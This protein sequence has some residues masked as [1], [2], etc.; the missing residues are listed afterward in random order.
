[1]CVSRNSL[2]GENVQV[3]RFEHL[4]DGRFAV[5]RKPQRSWQSPVMIVPD[6]FVPKAGESYECTVSYTPAKFTYNGIEHE[7]HK[8]FLVGRADI[9]DVIDHTILG[10]GRK[11]RITE[12]PFKALAGLKAGLKARHEVIEVRTQPGRRGGVD[13]VP[14]YVEVDARFGGMK[15]MR[16]FSLRSPVKLALGENFRMKVVNSRSLGKTDKRGYLMVV[17]EVELV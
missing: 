6:D 16:L 4:Y 14:H 3:L 11:E 10:K 17:V 1:M 13:F 15:T 7:I 12:N 5:I 9:L 8:A 2:E